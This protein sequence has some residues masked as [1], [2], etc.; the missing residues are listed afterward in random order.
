MQGIKEL[1]RL[2]FYSNVKKQNFQLPQQ[3]Q[4]VIGKQGPTTLLCIYFVYT[5][6]YSVCQ[7]EEI[8]TCQRVFLSLCRNVIERHHIADYICTTALF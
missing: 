5:V 2:T 6:M 4:F 1:N 7:V 8:N 3:F